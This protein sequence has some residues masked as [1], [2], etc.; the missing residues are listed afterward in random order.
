[1]CFISSG[2][3][4]PGCVGAV[5]SFS[6]LQ[7]VSLCL[8]PNRIREDVHHDG[9]T[10]EDKGWSGWSGWSRRHCYSTRPQETFRDLSIF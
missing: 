5:W 3:P 10:G 4:G 9:D 1:M 6:G 2:V 8:R 7:R